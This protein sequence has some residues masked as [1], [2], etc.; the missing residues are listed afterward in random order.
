MQKKEFSM[1]GELSKDEEKYI[2]NLEDELQFEQN[3]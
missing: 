2:S 1:L 3:L